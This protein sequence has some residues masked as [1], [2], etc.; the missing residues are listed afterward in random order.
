MLIFILQ[1]LLVEK[2]IEMQI[3]NSIIHYQLTNYSLSN[4]PLALQQFYNEST[5]L[6]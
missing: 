3:Y 5:L 1:P 2:Y 6:Y 4:Y